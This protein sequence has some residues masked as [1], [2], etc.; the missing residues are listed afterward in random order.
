MI[1][2]KTALLLVSVFLFCACY[3]VVTSYNIYV[4]LQAAI[5][6]CLCLEEGEACGWNDKIVSYSRNCKYL[7]D[8]FPA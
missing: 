1:Y 4:M 8:K 7:P 6:L 2:Y 3:C 5:L